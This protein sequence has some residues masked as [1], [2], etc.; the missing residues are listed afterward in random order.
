MY[1][2]REFAKKRI[3]SGVFARF[4]L[5][6]SGILCDGYSEET[7]SSKVLFG[8]KKSM[9]AGYLSDCELGYCQT[10]ISSMER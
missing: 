2:I 10:V 6:L 3:N 1:T 8:N 9:V 5:F 7:Y 4:V